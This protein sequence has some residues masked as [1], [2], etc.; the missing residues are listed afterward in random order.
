[1]KKHIL[2][3][4]FLFQ[5]SDCHAVTRIA[6]ISNKYFLSS[7]LCKKYKCLLIDKNIKIPTYEYKVVDPKTGEVFNTYIKSG[8]INI[9]SEEI[10][11]NNIR[12]DLELGSL[13]Y[14]ASLN[15]SEYLRDLVLWSMGIKLDLKKDFLGTT[16]LVSKNFEEK[17]FVEFSSLATGKVGSTFVTFYLRTVPWYSPQTNLVDPKKGHLAYGIVDSSLFPDGLRR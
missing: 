7:S 15:A 14:G 3:I 12:V 11:K 16:D 8:S 9:I 5:I 1:M 10:Q 6:A 4:L 2:A 17:D 13:K